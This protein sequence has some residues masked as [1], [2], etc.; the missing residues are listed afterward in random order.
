MMLSLI[1]PSVATLVGTKRFDGRRI[2]TG[3]NMKIHEV[4]ICGGDDHPM[5]LGSKPLFI[6]TSSEGTALIELKF[7]GATQNNKPSWL[8]V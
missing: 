2:R 6:E 7:C 3:W 5:H 1:N 4:D 8:N